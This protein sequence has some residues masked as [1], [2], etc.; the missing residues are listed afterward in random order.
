MEVQS[1]ITLLIKRKMVRK[2]KTKFKMKDGA[3]LRSPFRFDF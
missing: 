1:H 3:L 2:N